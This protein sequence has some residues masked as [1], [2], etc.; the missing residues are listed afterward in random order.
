MPGRGIEPW[1]LIPSES[2][3]YR[4]V[5]FGVT[6]KLTQTFSVLGRYVLVKRGTRLIINRPATGRCRGRVASDHCDRR[7]R[8]LRRG[9]RIDRAAR[10][11]A[12]RRRSFRGLARRVHGIELTILRSLSARAIGRRADG[13]AIRC[14][15][16][17]GLRSVPVCVHDAG[18]PVANARAARELMMSVPPA[19]TLGTFNNAWPARELSASGIAVCAILNRGSQ[20]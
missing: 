6:Q 5:T 14:S 8:S 3:P 2:N 12:A 9:A 17:C 4:G 7:R 10:H 18:R 20:Q 11:A 15:P 19:V 13:Y 1:P 16:Y